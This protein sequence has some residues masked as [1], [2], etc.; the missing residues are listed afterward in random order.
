MGFEDDLFEYGFNDGHD[1]IDYL[2]DKADQEWER[3]ERR[4]NP[5]DKDACSHSPFLESDYNR[6]KYKYPL[7]EL[8]S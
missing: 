4:Y 7:A 1:Y 2:M 8:E 6:N 5:K 3:L